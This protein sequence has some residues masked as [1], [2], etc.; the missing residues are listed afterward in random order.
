[1]YFLLLVVVHFALV[2]TGLHCV[3]VS[4]VASENRTV[5]SEN[6]RYICPLASF[7]YNYGGH[8]SLPRKDIWC[9]CP[10]YVYGLSRQEIA[11][12]PPV[13]GESPLLES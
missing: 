10:I 6:R 12:L 1:M 2:M 7:A 11:E 5:A 4:T 13:T 3:P 9:Q 8:H